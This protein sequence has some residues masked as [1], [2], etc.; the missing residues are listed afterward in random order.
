MGVRHL[1]RQEAD[2]RLPP[3]ADLVL[4]VFQILLLDVASCLFRFVKF[5][6]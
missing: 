4:R 2:D 3:G 5:D 1:W 6:L